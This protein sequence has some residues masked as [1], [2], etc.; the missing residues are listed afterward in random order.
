[1]LHPQEKL[2]MV[3]DKLFKLFH[4]DDTQLQLKFF[5]SLKQSRRWQIQRLSYWVRST[6]T[7]LLNDL[8]WT[9]RRLSKLI[10]TFLCH[11]RIMKVVKIMFNHRAYRFLLMKF[12]QS[13][14]EVAA[15]DPLKTLTQFIKSFIFLSVIRFIL[16]WLTLSLRPQK[17]WA[18]KEPQ[19]HSCDHNCSTRNLTTNYFSIR[20]FPSTATCG[21]T[22][23]NLHSTH[24]WN[25][26]WNLVSLSTI[27]TFVLKVITRVSFFLRH[28]VLSRLL[29]HWNRL[30]EMNRSDLKALETN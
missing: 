26:E 10:E 14:D 23:K 25:D 22:W 15:I 13:F 1:M 19:V 3:A 7:T 20:T 27:E 9:H 16:G 30:W 29:S 4:V 5:F 11:Q 6:S 2:L 8:L 18:T 12:R 17:T 28:L 24:Q 21:C